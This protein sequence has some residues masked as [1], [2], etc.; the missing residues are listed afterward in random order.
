MRFPADENGM[1]NSAATA[2]MNSTVSETLVGRTLQPAV[3]L[4]CRL[5]RLKPFR[6]GALLV[7]RNSL[8]RHSH[9]N[10]AE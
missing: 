8:D 2:A 3:Y 9:L 5:V 7:S 6:I 4:I 10:L 1:K